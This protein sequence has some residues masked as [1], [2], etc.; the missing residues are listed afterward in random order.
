MSHVCRTATGAALVLAL[1]GP[2]LTS[3]TPAPR[4]DGQALTSG[5][6]AI[7]VDVVVRDRK[8]KPVTDLAAEDFEVEEDG[9]RQRVDTFTRVSRGGGIGVGVAWKAL[10]AGGGPQPHLADS[11]RPAEGSPRDP[12]TA[13][14]VFDHLSSESLSLAQRA[15]L[16]YVPLSG[17]SDV[18]IGVFATDPGVRMLQDYTADRALVRQA[19]ARLVPSGTTAEEEKADRADELAGRRRALEEQIQATV[20]ST[21]G[22]TGAT[23][24][25]NAAETGL[26]ETELRLVQTELNIIRSFD[27]LDRDHRGYDTFSALLAVLKSLSHLA[28]RKTVVYFS[29]GLPVSPALSARLD[30]VID[31]ANRANVTMY[32]ID[33]HGLRTK[34]AAA[35]IQ[36]EMQ[37]FVEERSSQLA[38]GTD[39]THQPLTMGFE[40]VEDTLRIDSRTGL[41]RLAEHTGG[42][43]FE[44]S[45]DLTAAFRRMDED[46]QFHY[47]L[48]YSPTNTAF[49]GKFR[50]IAVKVRRPGM[51]VF[52]R[53][54]YRALKKAPPRHTVGTHD[55]NAL[56]LLER[57]PLPNAFPAHAAAFT[58]PEPDRPGLTA[59]L[60]RV[61]TNALHF[62]IDEK[63]STYRGQAA[64]LVR[65]RD[66]RKA[67]VQKLSQDYIVAGD[68]KDLEAAKNGDIIFYRQ[69]DLPPGIYTLESM[70]YDPGARTGSARIGT[71]TVPQPAVSPFG[72]SSLLL[73]NRVEDVKKV[74]TAMSDTT[75]P[76]YVGSMLVYPNL[77]ETIQQSR[78]TELP[79]FFTLYGEVRRVKV[80]AQLLRNGQPLAEAPVEL[81]TA[82]SS[83]IQH[84]GRLPIGSL[85]PGTYELRIRATD[86]SHELSRT[87]FFTLQR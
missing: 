1:S 66:E 25:Q 17:E 12:A 34:S 56:A 42:L 16:Q 41:A 9:V 86:G 24:A 30:A 33:A 35:N 78:T 23:L 64:I 45:N 29:E 49:D 85:S 6:T 4:S 69:V 57:R 82:S 44:A 62:A 38:R 11:D 3:Q 77:G 74:A 37:A 28:G 31:A 71:L 63:Q 79:F 7:L 52:A 61:N 8:G 73:V 72:L 5:A 54:G 32:A 75:G 50:T 83:R 70:V 76:L 65:I 21:A 20:G 14:I 81:V 22:A 51:Q 87:A 60:V 67:D 59:I 10:V 58:F 15:T 26:R 48:T 18:S 80:F 40:R 36:K 27:N 68:A 84:V 2:A 47:M 39:R 43:L 19:I 46:H 13:A 55:T 53:K